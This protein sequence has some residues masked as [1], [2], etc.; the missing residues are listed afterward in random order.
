LFA[1]YS[2]AAPKH[3]SALW[4]GAS[5]IPLGRTRRQHGVQIF[6]YVIVETGHALS[7][8]HSPSRPGCRAKE[9][10]CLNERIGQSAN[11]G[12][13]V[14]CRAKEQDCLNERIGQSANSGNPVLSPDE[15]ANLWD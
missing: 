13:P 3:F 6:R 10:D 2:R 9:Q 12:N 14:L 4:V 15:L 8:H 1:L 7:L 11:S 5:L